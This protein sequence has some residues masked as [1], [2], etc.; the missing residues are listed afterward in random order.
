LSSPEGEPGYCVS[1]GDFHMLTPVPEW[2]GS[3]CG[4]CV[5][6][7]RLDP[8]EE[9]PRHVCNL[10]GHRGPGRPEY[11]QC[12]CGQWL[13]SRGTFWYRVDHPPVRWLREHGVDPGDFWTL[14][15]EHGSAWFGE[16]GPG[17]PSLRWFL[18]WLFSGRP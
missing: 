18:R 1:C 8:P 12:S 14:D 7:R 10:S 2:S 11:R 6:T 4:Q 13:W 17:R 15:D 5:A 16:A 3:A 9:G